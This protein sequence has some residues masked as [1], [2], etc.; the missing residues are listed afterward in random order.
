MI[1]TSSDPPIRLAEVVAA[2]SLATDLGM[3][4]PL[5]FALRS[6]I[7]AVRLGESLGL[8][9][10]ALH[11]VYYQSLL[12]YI[13]CNVE[14]QLLAAVVGDELA[15]R[16][17]FA[18]VDQGSNAAVFQLMLRYIRQA[19]SGAAPL[20]Y[21]QGLLQGIARLP[22]IQSGFSAHC[23][24]AQ[25]LA[26][27]M[28][29]GPNI[30]YALGQL[31]ERWDGKGLPKGLKGEAIAPAVLVVTLAQDALLFQRLDGIDAAVSVIRERSGAAYAP[32]IADCFC[33]HAAQL[34]AGLEDE[35]S[36]A[37]VLEL[38]PGRREW[39]DAAG[40]DNACRA[41]ADFVDIK[42]PATL[43]HSSQ[44]AELTAHAA[45]H[46]GLPAGEVA[47][48]RRAGWLHD[49]GK[50][51]VPARILHKPGPL[52][53]R[54][55]EQV[56]LHPYH[57]SRILAHSEALGPLGELAAMHHER[58]DGSGYHRQLP[59]A[60]LPSGARLLAAANAYR[61]LL[62]DRPYRAGITPEAAA[63]ELARQ[64]RAGKLD[65]EAVQQV[66]TA[67]GHRVPRGINA[68][69]LSERE[70]E[71][72][73][74]LAQGH[75]TRQIAERLVISAKTADHHIQHI[76]NKIGVSTRVGATLFAM[77]HDLLP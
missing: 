72:L 77:E 2:L 9:D 21:A 69:G 25:R 54:E 5:E 48:L 47:T 27:R 46:A 20:D 24:V 22:Q 3:G 10:E 60:M 68:A 16:A 38:E 39:L 52:S 11:E 56:R 34:F 29:F 14:T 62:E 73:C 70:V 33:Q 35:P 17:D 65:G 53:E 37:S 42:Q 31:Y 58:P 59:A 44:V 75:S 61:A 55:W 36:W 50:T 12:R 19:N 4:Q 49:I 67:A 15:L 7:L 66:L 8:S 51:G 41:M 6:C 23:E 18:M 13:G 43:N 71:V 63:D 1:A 30:V 40:F 64:A 74:L 57:A 76:Y 26:E 45:G 28:G 32:H